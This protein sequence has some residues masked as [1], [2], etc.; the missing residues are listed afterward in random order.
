M[1]VGWK[2]SYDFLLARAALTLPSRVVASPA[3][4]TAAAA[5]MEFEECLGGEGFFQDGASDIA[6]LDGFDVGGESP[7]KA[8]GLGGG[9]PSKAVGLGGESPGTPGGGGRCGESPGPGKAAGPGCPGPATPAESPAT[10]AAA[11]AA[12]P[13]KPR[14]SKP[15][16]GTSKVGMRKCRG[17][18]KVFE[19]ASYPLNSVF[20]ADDKRALDVIARR[21]RVQGEEAKKYYRESREDPA[22]AKQML[23]LY[24]QSVGGRDVDQR[25]KRKS[26]QFCMLRCMETMKASTEVKHV[27]RHKAMWKSQFL[28]WAQTDEGGRLD[29]AAAQ[30]KWDEYEADQ[31]IAR[32]T[33]DGKLWLY[34]PAEK[35]LDVA[36]VVARS[37]EMHACEKEIKKNVDAELIEK[38]KRRPLLF[39]SAPCVRVF[40]C[41]RVCI[42]RWQFSLSQEA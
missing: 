12:K 7:S 40:V 32:E 24:W 25:N 10:P 18:D 20:C 5:A 33:A 14:T 38:S 4:C 22:K 37:K 34:V 31:S 8:V 9:S 13:S 35:L 26:G 28:R 39:L 17:C 41:V 16:S 21:A 2:A 1:L 36:N 3:R 11:T 15:K 6:M 42:A 27:N 19:E 30:R 29:D 23:A